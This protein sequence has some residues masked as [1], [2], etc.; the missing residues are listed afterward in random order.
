MGAFD[1]YTSELVLL[2]VI[3]IA[4][5]ELEIYGRMSRRKPQVGLED[6]DSVERDVRGA[7]AATTYFWFLGGEPQMYDR[8]ESVH[9]PPGRSKPKWG[10]PK[11]NPMAIP[12][13]SVRYYAD[14]LQRL[15]EL[16]RTSQE[17][18]TGLVHHSPFARHDTH[19][20]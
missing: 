11:V 8:I 14:P 12:A 15:I 19:R 5:A 6:W 1:H 18:S 13:S 2:Y 7:C 9:T 17:M 16:H 10:R 3:V 20:R 4:A